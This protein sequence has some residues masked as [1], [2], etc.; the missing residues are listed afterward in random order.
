MGGGDECSVALQSNQGGLGRFQRE[1]LRLPVRARAMEWLKTAIFILV[2]GMA[3]A[4]FGW[5]HLLWWLVVLPVLLCAFIGLLPKNS[6]REM[7]RVWDWSRADFIL[8]NA[9]INVAIFGASWLIHS[10][11]GGQ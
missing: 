4:I 5:L 7:K 3:S 1:N 2:T 9:V 6:V 11:S 10:H 8:W